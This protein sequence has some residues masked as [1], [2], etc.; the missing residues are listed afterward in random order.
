MYKYIIIQVLK[1]LIPQLLTLNLDTS[2]TIQYWRPFPIAWHLE[3]S[4]VG[5]SGISGILE[6]R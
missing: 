2:P 5:V 3:G 6:M 1:F 4:I